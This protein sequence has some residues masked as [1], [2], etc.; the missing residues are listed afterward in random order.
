MLEKR[1]I[2]QDTVQNKVKFVDAPDTDDMS[3]DLSV[4]DYVVRVTNDIEDASDGGTITINL[5][6]VVDATGRIYSIL[7]TAIANDG[8]GDAGDVVVT[9][10]GDDS[11]FEGDYTLTA[12]GDR[13]VLYSDGFSWHAL[14]E[15]TT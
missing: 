12:A 1:F 15:T 5:P 9:S 13:V 3:V 8:D 7:A 4:R 11:N 14:A 6:N 2:E 10:Q